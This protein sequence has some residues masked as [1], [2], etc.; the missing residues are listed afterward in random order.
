MSQG[1][2]GQAYDRWAVS[3]AALDRAPGGRTGWRPSIRASPGRANA[4]GP[5]Q[6]DPSSRAGTTRRSPDPRRSGGR[7]VPAAGSAREP[8]DW[9]SRVPD[10]TDS[11]TT[12][13]ASALV[14]EEA[15]P[16]STIAGSQPTAGN[17]HRSSRR[18]RETGPKDTP[19]LTTPSANLNGRDCT[20]SRVSLGVVFANSGGTLVAAA[21]CAVR[22]AGAGPT[23]IGWRTGGP[24]D[25]GADVR[26][27]GE[28]KRS[29]D[30]A[31]V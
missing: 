26:L 25:N 11:P 19:Q 6:P 30:L 3:T 10:I 28:H 7:T 23:R 31:R 21:N 29:L 18:V 22:W 27:P 13:V 1:S 5:N 17:G 12:F 24:A 15:G 2:A 4:S 14:P 8:D 16:P 9:N 20:G